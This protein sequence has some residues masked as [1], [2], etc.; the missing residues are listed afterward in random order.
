MGKET[1]L[2]QLMDIRIN[3]VMNGIVNSDGEY[4]AIIRKSDEY[5]D[6]LDG[7]ELPKEVLVIIVILQWQFF[8]P[9]IL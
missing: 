9:A 3:S 7:M 1:A 4:Q 2:Y 5:S 8:N 6:K